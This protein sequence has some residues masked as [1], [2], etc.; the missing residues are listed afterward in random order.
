MGVHI[1]KMAKSFKKT[2]DTFYT[3]FE[4]DLKGAQ[5]PIR[6]PPA[7]DDDEGWTEYRKHLPKMGLAVTMEHGVIKQ[8]LE[9]MMA[10]GAFA[11]AIAIGAVYRN[12]VELA[13]THKDIDL[14]GIARDHIDV[15]ASG[16]HSFSKSAFYFCPQLKTVLK[17]AIDKQ[18][19]WI[20]LKPRGSGANSRSGRK[21]AA[22]RRREENEDDAEDDTEHA[23]GGS[24]S[25]AQDDTNVNRGETTVVDLTDVVA[26][27]QHNAPP[28][29]LE[30][31]I[32]HEMM[33]DPVIVVDS[34]QTYD[35]CNIEKWF[36]EGHSTCP[37]TN[38]RLCTNRLV[39]NIAVRKMVR[40]WKEK[41][42]S[43]GNA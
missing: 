14:R 23:A 32:G 13:H 16:N 30:C 33:Q 38:K 2:F 40:D 42:P 20:G 6:G 34:G 7:E 26:P 31:P 28:D 39:E 15:V 22:K 3:V 36:S 9:K 29:A 11:N 19:P 21:V 12:L 4:A 5:L 35:R 18:D 10:S 8:Q 24:V 17:N 41:N 25:P 43:S 1:A 37:L 27:T